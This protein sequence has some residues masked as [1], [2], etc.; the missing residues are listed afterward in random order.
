M[1]FS[2]C[3]SGRS[4]RRVMRLESG[5]TDRSQTYLH[6]HRHSRRCLSYLL[7]VQPSRTEQCASFDP[8]RAVS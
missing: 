2:A 4:I 6:L 7:T 3:I 1:I 5:F 8:A